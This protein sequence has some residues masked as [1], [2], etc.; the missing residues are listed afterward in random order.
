MFKFAIPMNIDDCPE[1]LEEYTDLITQ[2]LSNF[3]FSN[4]ESEFNE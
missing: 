2:N 1:E 3:I 4:I